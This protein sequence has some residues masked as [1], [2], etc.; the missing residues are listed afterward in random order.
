MLFLGLIQFA[1]FVSALLCSLV[2]GLVFGFAIVVI[3]SIKSLNDHDFL[4]GFKVMYCVI[5]NNQLIFILVWLDS[6]AAFLIFIVLGIW[7]LECFD[8]LLLIFRDSITLVDPMELLP[9]WNLVGILDMVTAHC[10][11]SMGSVQNTYE[12]YPLGLP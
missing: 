7:Q 6:A 12:I 8:G 5:Q 9:N 2:V 11:V 3:P 10:E 1:I 4:Q